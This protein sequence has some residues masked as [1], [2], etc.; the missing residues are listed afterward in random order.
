MHEPVTVLHL[1][2]SNFIGGPEKQILE[3]FKRLDPKRFRPLLCCFRENGQD[4]PLL[5]RAAQLGITCRTINCTSAFDPMIISRLRR[6]LITDKID[7]LC[8]HGY[9][10]NILGRIASLGTGVKAVA[11]S[12]G[13]TGENSKIRL[14]EKLDKFFLRHASHIVAVSNGQRDKIVALGIKPGKVT[15]IHN[16]INLAE[17]TEA[18]GHLLRRELGLPD[19]A[20]IVASAGRLSPEKNYAAMIEASQGLIKNNPKIFF[21]IFGEG[22]LR[23][24]LEAQIT[25]TGL[26][27]RFLLPGFRTDL[28]TVLHDIDIFMLPS[29]SE[30]LPNVVLEAFAARKPVVATRVGGTPEVVQ[31]GISGFLTRPDEPA[32]MAKHV[33]ALADDPLLRRKMGTAGY[34]YVNNIFSFRQQTELY[35]KLYVSLL[36]SSFEQTFLHR[37]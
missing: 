16:A 19:D 30:G 6:V 11:I 20:T 29:F 37:E 31:D 27:G 9:K 12:R 13:W 7:I 18:D 5:E 32:L 2:I 25:L 8:T 22:F 34:N 17:I 21:A 3:H 10:P 24:E 15:V 14:Y 33:L 26:T 4:D 28:Q 23:P 36:D 35:E 1:R